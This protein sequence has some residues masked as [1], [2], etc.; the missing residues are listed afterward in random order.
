MHVIQSLGWYFPQSTGGS[1]VYVSGLVKQLHHLGVQCQ[2]AAPHDGTQGHAYLHDQAPVYRYPVGPGRTHGQIVGTEPHTG[3]D[4]FKRWL[5]T[6]PASVY[7]QHS[8]TFGCGVPHLQAAK[9]RGMATVLTV[10]V[11]GAV[12][13]RGTLLRNGRDPC[14]GT[15]RQSAC[16]ACWLQ[17]RG[18]GGLGRAVL[19]RIPP[20]VG[21]RLR[22]LGRAGTALAATSLVQR[23]Q[24]ALMQAADAADHV[25][26]VCQWLF[27]SLL[28]NG[29][30]PAKLSLNRQGVPARPDHAAPRAQRKA[31]QPLVLGFLGRSDPAKGLD[32]LVKA[33]RALE[34]DVPVELRVHAIDSDDAQKQAYMKSVHTL[35]QGDPRISIRPALPPAETSAFLRSIDMLAVPSRWFETGPLVVLEAFAVGTP[36]LGSNLGGVAELVRHGTTGW[37]VPYDDIGAWAAAMTRL[38]SDPALTQQ[39]SAGIGPVRT[40]QDVAGDTLALYRRLLSSRLGGLDQ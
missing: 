33:V 29:V 18:V 23:H 25:V 8:M 31:D 7:H 35:A 15:I 38:A 39:L 3:F 37:L 12:C 4:D 22:P 6:Q 40:V 14:D 21:A 26:A 36:I 10:H 34:P 11:P 19:S 13:L 16:A 32:T 9:A 28:S 30:P 20:S 27:D 17:D 24:T 2:I 1:E 5:G